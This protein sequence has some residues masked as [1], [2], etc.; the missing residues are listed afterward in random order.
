MV[1][2]RVRAIVL[3]VDPGIELGLT[4][5]E[6]ARVRGLGLG[7]E[8]F[9]ERRSG[10]RVRVRVRVRVQRSLPCQESLPELQEYQITLRDWS[11]QFS[12]L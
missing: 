2:V 8:Q 6:R 10:V 9:C 12:C 1:R 3:S 7:L 11:S 4:V 5:C